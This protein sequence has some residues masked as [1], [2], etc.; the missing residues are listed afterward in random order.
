MRNIL[1]VLLHQNPIIFLTIC[2]LL[3]MDFEILIAEGQFIQ[4]VVSSMF[5]SIKIRLPF[6]NMCN[7]I[8]FIFNL[9]GSS[10]YL[11]STGVFCIVPLGLY[12]ENSCMYCPV[13]SLS[14]ATHIGSSSSHKNRH[15]IHLQTCF[16]LLNDTKFKVRYLYRIQH[17]SGFDRFSPG[18]AGHEHRLVQLC[19]GSS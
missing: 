13:K 4:L 1:S 3:I 10:Q 2:N 7:H 9:V 18:S 17:S 11:L 8:V 16:W 6:I 15:H 12:T 14:S 5:N 19:N